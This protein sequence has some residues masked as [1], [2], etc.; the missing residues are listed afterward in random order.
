MVQFHV[1]RH[2]CYVITMVETRLVQKEGTWGYTKQLQCPK[3]KAW[4]DIDSYCM[5]CSLRKM[6][7]RY[8]EV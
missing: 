8:N 5:D 4:F 1:V 6:L 7:G 2:Y 3:C